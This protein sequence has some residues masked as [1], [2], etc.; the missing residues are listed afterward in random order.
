MFDTIIRG[1]TVIDGTG[2]QGFTA[3][4][5]I[6]DGTIVEIGKVAG[7]ARAAGFPLDGP[8]TANLRRLEHFLHQVQ[9]RLPGAARPALPCA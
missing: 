6:T 5:A 9:A 3:D 7:Q 8:L 4:V 1:A 2:A